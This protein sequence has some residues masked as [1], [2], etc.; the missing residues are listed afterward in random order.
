MIA[1][2]IRDLLADYLAM[3]ADID[4]LDA[5]PSTAERSGLAA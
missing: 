1:Q 4:A 3:K 2:M 5:E